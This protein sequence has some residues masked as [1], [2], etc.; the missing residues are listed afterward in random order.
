MSQIY[1]SL[2]SGPVPPSVA[3]SYVTDSG[4]AVPAFNILNVL[5]SPGVSTFG[6][7]NTIIITMTEVIPSYVNVT[8]PATYVVTATDYFISCNSTGGVITIEL[9]DSPTQ[10][11]R[12]VIKDRTGTA[13][14]NNITV[15]TVGGLVLI[16]GSTSYVFDEPYESIEVL[17]NGTSYEI[18]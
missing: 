8:G 6:V 16:D 11:D 4:V 12:F 18:F 15:T 1:K 5:G 17:F 14:S 3:T 7:G 13:L 2:S 9:P 10:Y